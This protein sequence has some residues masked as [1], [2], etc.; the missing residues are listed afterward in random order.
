MGIIEINRIRNRIAKSTYD[1]IDISDIQ[2]SLPPE[3]VETAHLSRGLAAFVLMK[4]A[5]ITASQ[6]AH[7]V[8]DGFNDNGIDAIY[9]SDSNP[10]K[11][12]IVQAKLSDTGKS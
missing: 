3:T 4:L 10:R 2:D 1:E 7:S 8:V 5:D 6:A 11:L 12:Y 9:V